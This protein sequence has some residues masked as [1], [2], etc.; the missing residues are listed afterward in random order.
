MAFLKQ[1]PADDHT[2]GMPTPFGFLGKP[3]F[4]VGTVWQ[5]DECRQIWIFTG[6]VDHMW[7]RGEIEDVLPKPPKGP[8][9]VQPPPR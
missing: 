2:C 3:R 9:G 8:A 4:G 6:H 1:V 5:C 7:E